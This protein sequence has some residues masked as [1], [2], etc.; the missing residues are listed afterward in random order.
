V[1]EELSH[2]LD[3]CRCRLARFSPRIRDRGLGSEM[4]MYT[5]AEDHMGDNEIAQVSCFLEREGET[6]FPY[7]LISQ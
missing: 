4:I 3:R 6:F 1:K 5:V 2:R 7:I